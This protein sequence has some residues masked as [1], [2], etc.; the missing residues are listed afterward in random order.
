M[1]TTL[2]TTAKLF[3]ERCGVPKWLY[4]GSFPPSR[5]STASGAWGKREGLSKTQVTPVTVTVQL[6]PSGRRYWSI[7][8][9][10]SRL[11]DSF[12]H[13]GIRLLNTDH[14][15]VTLLKL[16]HFMHSIN[17]YVYIYIY[18]YFIYIFD[19]LINS[20]FIELILH[21]LRTKINLNRGNHSKS[22]MTSN[23]L[24]DI[25][26]DFVTWGCAASR[27]LMSS[28]KSSKLNN[29]II[30]TKVIN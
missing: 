30:T 29:A 8:S 7:W 14:F 10:T 24:A 27:C 5:T 12:F 3:G 18:V 21:Y 1:A 17:V 6:L 15:T 13:Q 23:G 20:G 28:N 22:H 9:G 25:M 26:V 2:P 16:W 11:R 19:H 4:E